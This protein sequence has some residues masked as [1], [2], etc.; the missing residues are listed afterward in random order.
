MIDLYWLRRSNQPI[1]TTVLRAYNFFARNALLGHGRQ[2]KIGKK[3]LVTSQNI[4][5]LASPLLMSP[6]Y[7]VLDRS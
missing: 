7:D 3:H 1:D 2:K 4:F 6:I 5:A